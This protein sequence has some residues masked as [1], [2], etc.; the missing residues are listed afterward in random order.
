M[1]FIRLYSIGCTPFGG[2]CVLLCFRRSSAHRVFLVVAGCL[3]PCSCA[4]VLVLLVCAR[5]PA[6]R[7]GVCAFWGFLLLFAL[8]T[9]SRCCVSL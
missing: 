5:G 7:L 2:V 3:G 8:Y 4:P 1:L 6:L 9:Y